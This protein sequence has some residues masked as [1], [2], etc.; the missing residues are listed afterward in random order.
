MNDSADSLVLINDLNRSYGWEL[1]DSLTLQQLEELLAETL[2]GWIRSDFTKLVQFLYR[3]DI[4][5][6]RLKLLLEENTEEDTGQLLARLV[7]ERLWQKIQT[8]RQF[9]PGDAIS[10]EERW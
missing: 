8:R 7:L 6:S 2:N 5:E 1:A 10:D 4:S 3:I 9:K